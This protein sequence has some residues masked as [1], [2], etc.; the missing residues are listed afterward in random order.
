MQQ[1]LERI[2][3]L[4]ADYS[5]QNTPAMQR[6]G[7]LVRM[8]AAK[9]L[10]DHETVLAGDVQLDTNDFLVEGRDGTGLKTRV[11][12]LRFGSR[13]RSPRATQGFYVVYLFD[14]RGDAA[15]LSLNQGTTDFV[16]GDFVPKPS[17]ELRERV[18]WA[19]DALGDWLHQNE[20]SVTIDLHAR[21][22]GSGYERGNIA[23]YR[24]RR[25]AVPDDATLLRDARIYARGLG[26]L[27]AAQATRPLPFEAPEVEQ[28]MILAEEAAGRSSGARGAGFRMNSAEI[29]LIET[30]AVELARAY[31][32]REGW[33]VE[34]LG[35]PFDLKISRDGECLTVE[36]KGTTS[37]GSKVVLTAGEV[38]HHEE[39]YPDNALVVVR[40]IVLNRATTPP[41][42][43]GGVLYE[44]RGWSIASEDLQPISFSYTVPRTVYTA[45]AQAST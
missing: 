10:I 26:R 2:L 29:K 18:I 38:R 27:Y 21:G 41:T 19:R 12:W 9:W 31:Y 11:P 8:T 44:Q 24:Y 20:H 40:H 39:A 28:A 15:F 37:D 23:A 36:V 6:R 17:H 22:L 13:A 32:E 30:H 42:A 25:R 1:E 5:A 43:S 35:K 14:A 33:H 7:Q 4:Q 45:L 3:E 16:N 34:V